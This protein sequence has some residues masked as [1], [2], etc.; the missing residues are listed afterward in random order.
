MIGDRLRIRRR[1]MLAHGL[2]LSGFLIYLL[3]LADPLFE[4][5][6]AMP[7]ESKIQHLPLPRET[8]NMQYA[9]DRIW[10]T[11]YSIEIEGWGFVEKQDQKDGKTYVIMK[12]DENIYIFD[13]FTIR[14]DD[15]ASAW[16]VDIWTGFLAIIPLR[17]IQN[18]EYLLGIYIVKGNVRALKYVD[19]VIVKSRDGVKLTAWTSKLRR[20]SLPSESNGIRFAIDSIEEIS[21][22]DGKGFVEIKGWAFIEEWGSED[23]EIYLV[24]RSGRNAYVFDTMLVERPDVTAAFA[25]SG[26]DLDRSGFIARIPK[27]AVESGAYELGIYIR[28][29]EVEALRY[30][31]IKIANMMDLSELADLGPDALFWIDTINGKAIAQQPSPIAINASREETITICGWAVDKGANDSALAVFVTI[32]GKLDIPAYYG[33]DRPDVAKAFDNPKFRHSGFMA[34]FSSRILG[35]G[36]HTLGLKIVARDGRGY[37]RPE[38]TVRFAIE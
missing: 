13:T 19:K 26:L 25:E 38:G 32:D 12:S 34:T 30:T 1:R 7:Y 5:L 28:R 4:G 18:G 31:N 9:L 37:Y 15:V 29:G 8:G 6:E 35:R 2:I 36:E 14:R 11:E 20:A 3:F 27:G 17:K 23:S 22:N 10:I 21:E 33:L 16:N 24:L